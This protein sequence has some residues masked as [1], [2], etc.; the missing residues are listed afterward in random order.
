LDEAAI[1]LLAALARTYAPVGETPI[2]RVPLTRD[3]LSAISAITPEGRLFTREYEH[4]ITSKE[5]IEFVLHLLRY[6]DKLLLIWDGAPIHRSKQ[7]KAFL[8]EMGD[9]VVVEQLPAYAP[10][11]NPDEDVWRHVKWVELKN[12]CCDTFVH[13]W[14]EY[15]KAK[16]RLRRKPH[17][18]R[19]FF[20]HAGLV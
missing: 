8:A 19:A 20:A 10:E 16:Q 15:R 17:L 18:I 3:H 9:R 7:V 5:V 6:L 4:T 1:Y 13:L 11:L 14:H 12:V 2:L